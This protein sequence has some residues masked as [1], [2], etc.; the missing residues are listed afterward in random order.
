MNATTMS[1]DSST[2]T[3]T[4]RMI[5]IRYKMVGISVP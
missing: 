2:E 5:F 4:I 1:L 3:L